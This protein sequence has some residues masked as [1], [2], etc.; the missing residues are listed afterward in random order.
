M[1]AL[2]NDLAIVHMQ[3][4]WVRNFFTGD[5]LHMQVGNPMQVG[6]CKGKALALFC[7]DKHIDID[8]MNRFIATLI[9][10]TVA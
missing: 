10:T 8:R 9:A 2:I 6:Q 3:L 4:A 5:G 7:G 1:R